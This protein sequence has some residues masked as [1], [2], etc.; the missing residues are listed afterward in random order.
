M[1]LNNGNEKSKMLKI[2]YCDLLNNIAYNLN[3][4]ETVTH[5]EIRVT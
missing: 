5:S 4:A 3:M 2:S 1:E